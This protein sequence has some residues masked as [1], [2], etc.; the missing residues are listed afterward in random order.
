MSLVK[1]LAVAGGHNI[2]AITIIDPTASKAATAAIAAV[3]AAKFKILFPP[4]TD[5]SCAAVTGPNKYFGLI[6]KFHNSLL[7]SFAY[8]IKKGDTAIPL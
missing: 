3:R 1:S 5:A 4:E 8:Q 6:K 7:Y 2:I